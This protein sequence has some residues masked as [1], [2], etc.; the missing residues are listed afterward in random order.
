MNNMKRKLQERATSK[1]LTVGCKK[2]LGFVLSVALL[3]ESSGMQAFAAEMQGNISDIPKTISADNLT[4]NDET[5]SADENPS[6]EQ[7]GTTDGGDTDIASGKYKGMYWRI[8]K[9]GL[10]TIEGEYQETAQIGT[11][12]HDY[13]LQIR[14]AKVTATN[15]KST[16][17]WF[18][19]CY[20][21]TTADLSNF[22][23]S[24]VTNMSSMFRN[25]YSLTSLDLS[26]FDTSMVTDM[27][28]MFYGCSDLTSLDISNF[29]SSMVINSISMLDC[30][31]SL[32][33]LSLSDIN[34]TWC[35]MD[36][37]IDSTGLLTI[38][39]KYQEDAAGQN[40][41]SVAPGIK[42]AR[43]LATNVTSTNGW[44]KNCANLTSVDFSNFN[45]SMVIDM[46]YMFY[47]CHSLTSL[48]LSSFD[49]S[50]VTDMSYMFCACYALTSLD[51]SNFDTHNVTNM[52]CMFS[53]TFLY[54]EVPGDYVSALTSLDVSSFDTSKVT[55]MGGMF[56]GCKML[57]S[58][59][60]SNFDTSNVTNMR[61]MFYEC[62]SLTDL[63][64]NNFNGNN[65]VYMD[66][67]FYECHAL[68][69]LNMSNMN[70]TKLESAQDMLSGCS[71]LKCINAPINLSIDIILPSIMNDE[72]GQVHI[73]LPREQNT[74]IKLTKSSESSKDILVS[75]NWH[76]MDWAIDGEGS[77]SVSGL[78]N[79][80]SQEEPAWLDYSHIIKS[81]TVTAT[82]VQTAYC[83]FSSCYN[84]QYVNLKEFDT[85]QITDME[86]MF[87][88]C[89]SLTNLDLSNMNLA[90]L[91]SAGDMFYD[92]NN[93]ECIYSPVN[94]NIN[95]TLP[96]IMS[97]E[98]EKIY[99]E[100]PREQN[101]PIKLTKASEDSKDIFVS[102]NW[103][104]MDWTID[105]EGSLS[106][107][108]LCNNDLGVEP[109]WLDYSQIISS[110]KV[111]ATNVHNTEYWFASCYNL[112]TVDFNEFNTN[113]VINMREMFNDCRS[114][115]N[116]DLGNMDLT[117]LNKADRMLY[118]CSS[119][120]S[121][122]TPINLNIDINLPHAMIDT[123][124][125][126][127][128]KLPKGLTTSIKLIRP[129]TGGDTEDK[130][131]IA[132]G[133]YNGMDWRI[134]KDGLLTIEGEY[135]EKNQEN[136]Q[137]NLYTPSWLDYKDEITSTKVSAT[138][139]TST[140]GWFYGCHKLQ[141]T[142]FTEFDTSNVTNLGYMFY[143]CSALTGLDLSDMDLSK[144]GTADHEDHMLDNCSSLEW[145]NAPTNLSVS[146]SLPHAMSDK[147]GNA[148]T[149]L[150]LNQAVSLKLTCT[151]NF[152]VTAISGQTYTGKAIKPGITVTYGKR[153][154]TPGIDY[155]VTYKNN[156]NA[157]AADSAKA[158]AVTVKGKGN[159]ADSITQTF[160]I[161][162]KSLTDANTTVSSMTYTTDGKVK[163][164]IP[165]VTV[166]GVKLK[167]G[168]DYI[169]EFPD[170]VSGAYQQP[171]RYSVII[172]G[173]GNYQGTV[174]TAMIILSKDQIQASKLKIGKISACTYTE[175]TPATPV[176]IVTYAGKTLVLDKDYTISYRN[177]DK[178]G[179]ATLIITGLENAD[180]QGVYVYGT[181][182]KAFSVKG[183]ALNKAKINYDNK[184]FFT[185]SAICP[186]VTL[187]LNGAALRPGTDY[188]VSYSNNINAGKATITLTGCGGYTGTVKK[189]F[190][191]RPVETDANQL[192]VSFV[193]GSATASYS[194]SGAKPAVTVKI[195]GTAL[196]S[197]KDYAVTYKNNKKVAASD[198][199]KAPII[200][201]KGKG[202]YK[203]QKSLA[204][205]IV[206]KSLNDTDITATA[207]DT[208]LG[209]KGSLLA[210]PI[211]TDGNGKKLKAGKDYIT[212]GYFINGQEFNGQ[213]KVSSNTSVTVK[214]RGTG[215]YTG[216]T[217]ATYRI[218]AR[219]ISKTK[220]TVSQIEFNGGT[221]ILTDKMIQEG[222]IKVTDKATG[223]ELV[224]GTDYII[225]SYKNNARKG[226]A[227][228]I[229]QGI[230]ETYGGTKAVKF[231]IVARKLKR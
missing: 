204:F 8:D 195:S 87:R 39:G 12:W 189:T 212:I 205:S 139:V 13:Y 115:I 91:R 68:T 147:N 50:N 191:I 79:S 161:I 106:I 134:D 122:S 42:S 133:K 108:G 70:L 67:M 148:Y 153:I 6:D 54:G 141:K 47:G 181:V 214:L 88:N 169:A 167:A 58:L 140:W 114:L 82:N 168:K 83:W 231:N 2:L 78:C 222:K 227:T 162:A 28:Y 110:A 199:S 154:L 103:H 137:D 188:T 37:N 172:K 64:V 77:L 185:G 36:W 34:G 164:S 125:N 143:N 170:T 7:T 21:L 142:D 15:V 213:S 203:F 24:M 178:A 57:T 72:N 226:K 230:G 19:N 1:Q 177:N 165:A 29:D 104:G 101:T 155:T 215:C 80:S 146:I 112:H 22:D 20:N 160:A 152:A 197:G 27:S 211:V 136:D 118:G 4:E 129:S 38:S 65:V 202:N 116:I 56:S 53:E 76:G 201:I 11:N 193:T 180:S 157:A 121:L 198:A 52:F 145:I 60:I 163:K 32:T 98:Q 218:A 85:S 220:V 119:L 182:E 192:E 171:G 73:A 206:K 190:T 175:G 35:G 186:A 150:P 210:T 187:T 159:Y 100:L 26:N 111:T 46:S 132:S 176:P 105:G 93:L 217:E 84:L 75:E 102:G 33:N 156:T 228:L 109:D 94:L 208:F 74:P 17:G 16:G 99:I 209:T 200:I 95:I 149:A 59:D 48:D 229:I 123:D 225:T 194:Q 166:D 96:S 14:N 158:P 120:E 117:Q 113:K 66:E 86:D 61:G 124:G 219:D 126:T 89:H 40:W 92:C 18:W 71:S 63:K 43:V 196:Q 144:L 207:P 90:M 173:T 151:E 179:K 81:A 69:D 127:Y 224:Y 184:A 223:Q 30:C 45:T 131:T 10:L 62:S 5:G 138:H 216:E 49:T 135:Q 41:C 130:N 55:N 174:T 25:C 44:F 128:T 31:Y 183:T 23:T 51:V 221:T 107:S 3:L 9:D 97:D